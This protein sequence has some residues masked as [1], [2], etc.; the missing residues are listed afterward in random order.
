MRVQTQEQLEGV[1]GARLKT[2]KPVSGGD[3]AQAYLIE[4]KTQ[5]IFCKLLGG[6]SGLEMLRAE[7]EGLDQI[8]KSGAIKAPHVYFCESL[9]EQAC[10]GMEYIESKNPSPGEMSKLGEQL[11]RLHKSSSESFGLTSDNFIGSLPQSNKQHSSWVTFYVQERLLPQFQMALSRDRL[12]LH[13]IPKAEHMVQALS[14]YIEGISPALLHG[15]LWS[16]NYLISSA[17]DPYLI[18]PAVYYGDPVVD[19]AMS[20]LFGG[21]GGEFYQAYDANSVVSAN[22]EDKTQLYQLYYLLVHL[23]LFGSSYYSGVK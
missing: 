19:L 10:L 11:A 4:T 1:L 20:R 12:H 13:E 15:D 9:G 5:Q 3:I 23:N 14:P 7:M 22:E 6:T 8:R 18:D 16:G 17:G 21:F 2:V